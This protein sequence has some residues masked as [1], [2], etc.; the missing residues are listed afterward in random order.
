MLSRVPPNRYTEAWERQHDYDLYCVLAG[1]FW[2]L[3]AE[4]FR[5]V[6]RPG[7]KLYLELDTPA[8]KIIRMWKTCWPFRKVSYRRRCR[9]RWVLFL[10]VHVVVYM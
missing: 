3:E 2:P 9:S 4:A 1:Q 8:R 10:V 6:D 5:A 7:K